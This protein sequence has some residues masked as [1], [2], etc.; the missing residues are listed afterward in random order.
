MF[1]DG[2]QEG[3]S[4]QEE[5]RGGRQGEGRGELRGKWGPGKEQEVARA[6]SARCSQCIEIC[7][8]VKIAGKAKI[9]RSHD[10]WPRRGTCPCNPA[11][12]P[13][14]LLASLLGLG[15]AGDSGNHGEAD[16]CAGGGCPSVDLILCLMFLGAVMF[17]MFLSWAILWLIMRVSRKK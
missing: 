17:G 3:A 5:E 4:G 6:G 16:P 1:S 10:P 11:M 15:S 9:S 2:G 12:L 7:D 14:L 8:G 13:L